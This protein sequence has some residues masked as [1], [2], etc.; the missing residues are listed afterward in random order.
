MIA[1]RSAVLYGG[2][3]A[4]KHRRSHDNASVLTVYKEYLGEPNG[5]EAHNLLHTHYAPR[6]KYVKE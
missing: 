2:D 3:K 1:K 5:H 4:L 6:A